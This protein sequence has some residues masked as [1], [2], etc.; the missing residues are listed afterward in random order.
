MAIDSKIEP[1]LE[2]EDGVRAAGI[3]QVSAT[4]FGDDKAAQRSDELDDPHL[5]AA[6]ENIGQKMSFR[7]LAA[8]CVRV[9]CLLA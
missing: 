3:D 2:I 7:T 9:Y 8:I 6:A 4:D 1:P 5:A